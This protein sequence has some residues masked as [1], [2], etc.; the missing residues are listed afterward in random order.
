MRAP[1]LRLLRTCYIREICVQRRE[2]GSR[3]FLRPFSLPPSSSLSSREEICDPPSSFLKAHL[4]SRDRKEEKKRRENIVS[5]VKREKRKE[6][7][8]TAD[9]KD[10][11]VS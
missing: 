3:W 5:E 2:R 7:W 11:D 4:A 8:K 10:V 9:T 6:R 1:H